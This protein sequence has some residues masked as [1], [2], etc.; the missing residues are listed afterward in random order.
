MIYDIEPCAKP[1]MTKRDK[2]AKRPCVMKYRA[3]KDEC[4]LKGLMIENMNTVVFRIAMP[5][6]WSKKKKIEMNE[7][8]HQQKPDIDNLLKAVM[9]AVLDDDSHISSISVYKI[10]AHQG[11]I[12][13]F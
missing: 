2:W 4:N 5:K 10:W 11:S 9:D 13:I 6:T 8:P 3:F 1:R 12:E 7:T